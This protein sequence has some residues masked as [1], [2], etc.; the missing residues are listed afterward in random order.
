MNRAVAVLAAILV[1]LLA[2]VVWVAVT[3]PDA[4]DPGTAPAPT[5]PPRAV[6]KRVRA[7]ADPAAPVSAETKE[8][9][10]PPDAASL[11]VR[12]VAADGGAPVKGASVSVNDADCEQWSVATD[13]DGA[14]LFAS[15]PKGA[16]EVRVEAKGRLAATRTISLAAREAA[17]VEIPLEPAA[18]LEGVLVDAATGAPIADAE[19]EI[20]VKD[21]D[22]GDE[23]LLGDGRS[24]EKG[25][26]RVES[27]PASGRAVLRVREPGRRPREFGV[28]LGDATASRVEVSREIAGRLYGTVQTADGLP[29]SAASVLLR[30]ATA[31]P[32]DPPERVADC[33]ADGS[34]VFDD[35]PLGVALVAV[36]SAKGWADAVPTETITFGPAAAERRHDF[37]LRRPAT[38]TV[39]VPDPSKAGGVESRLVMVRLDDEPTASALSTGSGSVLRSD[40][41]PGTHR[42]RVTANGFLPVL[43]RVELP[44]GGKAEIEVLLTLGLEIRGR[45][46]DG[47]GA[48]LAHAAVSAVDSE[49]PDEADRVRK[50]FTQAAFADAAGEFRFTGLRPGSYRLFAYS[51][52]GPVSAPLVVA[53]PASGLTLVLAPGTKISLHVVLPAGVAAPRSVAAIASADTIAPNL[54]SED[55]V[56]LRAEPLAWMEHSTLEA[57]VAAGMKW[58]RIVVPG[59]A[60]TVVPMRAEP[61][62]T[63]DLGEVRLEPASSVRGRVVDAK[64]DGI[65]G[66]LV[67]ATLTGSGAEVRSAA[68]GSF[69]VRGLAPGA[70]VLRAQGGGRFAAVEAEA[71]GQPTTITMRRT[72]TLVGVV[73]DEDGVP[74]RGA[75]FAIRYGFSGDARDRGRA[76]SATADGD[77]RIRVPVGSGLVRVSAGGEWVETNVPEGGEAEVT[78]RRP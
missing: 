14:A 18:A 65:G 64:G 13:A 56:E 69:E 44:E 5:G 60:P 59:C 75:D 62:K 41:T 4:H 76:D 12:V 25:R 35:V 70:A 42:V 27:L 2:A 71:G 57:E 55:F 33:R 72:G 22:S 78:V 73:A 1:A 6:R 20:V 63:T 77:G 43:R 21:E 68:D 30:R 28:A 52:T 9:P 67:W 7:A 36:A 45:V 38:L 11:A 19:L 61:G 15:L 39:N 47:A 31:A 51:G 16:T 8:T 40:L 26:Y 53:A 24:D 54:E 17:R 48:G 58:L 34:Y 3:E 49:L 23:R 32:R 10:P 29:A 50:D 74:V 46:V 37:T 66:V